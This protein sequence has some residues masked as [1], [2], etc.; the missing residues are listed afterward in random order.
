MAKV[1]PLTKQREVAIEALTQRYNRD[2]L[3]VVAV[4]YREFKIIRKII[5]LLTKV[6]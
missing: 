6:I 3:R 2:G 5:Q 1:E 4:A